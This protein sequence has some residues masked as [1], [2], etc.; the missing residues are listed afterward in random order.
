MSVLTAQRVP[1]SGAGRTGER[2]RNP[3]A[4]LPQATVPTAIVAGAIGPIVLWWH[5]T[6]GVHGFGDWLTNAGRLT[7]LLAGY[8]LAVLLLLMA[9]VPFLER[10]IGSDRLARWH[11]SGGRYVVCLAS[12]H[13][14]L[15]IWGYAVTAHTNVVAQTGTLLTSYP[16]V[17][18]ATAALGLLVLTGVV[19]MRAARR[20]LR[21]ETWYYLHLYTYLAVAL[22]FS[23]QF[24]TGA[25]FMNDRPARV[26]WSAGYAIAIAA[27][28]WYRFATPIRR[29]LRHRL[30]VAET[31]VEA[32]G[33]VS[34]TLVGRH[35][36]ELGAEPGQF[37]RWRFLSR[38]L[39]WVSTPYSLSAPAH[40]RAIRITGKA[41]GDHSA[42]L[43][44]LRP[45]TPVYAEGP[46]GA[47]TADR[48][49]RR[50]VLLLA[51]GIGITPLR[52]LAQTLPATPGDLT[53]VYRVSD[54]RELVFRDELDTLAARRGIR[55]HYLVGPRG[56]HADPLVG[57]RLRRLVP[58][59]AEHDVYVCGPEPFMAAATATLRR[60]G[61]P[62]SRVHAESFAF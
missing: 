1:R 14:L 39:W 13:A 49:T 51:G 16:D 30:R 35:L 29:A 7:G 53:L 4:R 42:Q 59:L 43:A 34:V 8:T 25:D 2:R 58:D 37:F 27:V 56:G 9:R 44:E 6:I 33:V 50:R 38:G 62:A 41:L 19:S 55:V 61:V 48:R 28:V 36:D 45:G 22:A 20:R 5:D 17:L 60:S 21:Y 46:Y 10:G 31:R 54:E 12:A 52:A 57:D 24:A 47:F 40:P 11:A 23:H 32:P 18:M 3:L 15:V 26:L